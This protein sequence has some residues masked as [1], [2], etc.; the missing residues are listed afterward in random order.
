MFVKRLEAFDTSVSSHAT[1]PS[2]SLALRNC[3]IRTR[4]SHRNGKIRYF[5]VSCNLNTGALLYTSNQLFHAHIY[6]LV[7]HTASPRWRRISMN[8]CL[9]A[10]PPF[11]DRLTVEKALKASTLNLPVHL[12]RHIFCP[13]WNDLDLHSHVGC[14]RIAKCH[15]VQKTN[16][17]I[18]H[19]VWVSSRSLSCFLVFGS[20]HVWNQ[21]LLKVL[22]ASAV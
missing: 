20:W 14:A 9:N 1:F 2:T 22:T 7:L 15:V 10:D 21:V 8:I 12:S 13:Q 6:S 16:I 19:S 4:F 11:W 17:L 18:S 5:L 3:P